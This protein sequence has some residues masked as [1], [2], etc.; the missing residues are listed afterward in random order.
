MNTNNTQKLS[1]HQRAV[2]A[3][4]ARKLE[5]GLCVQCGRNP[6]ARQGQRVSQRCVAC[7]SKMKEYQR[8]YCAPE[9]TT[10]QPWRP[11]GPGRPPVW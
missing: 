6:R 1:A 9:G 11:G 10:F 5:A 4:K 8:S 7:I 3:Y 2:M